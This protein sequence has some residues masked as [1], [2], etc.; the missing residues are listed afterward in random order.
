MAQNAHDSLEGLVISSDSMTVE[1]IAKLRYKPVDSIKNPEDVEWTLDEVSNKMNPGEIWLV[2]VF[3]HP[4][5]PGPQFAT[6]TRVQT[7][8]SVRGVNRPL[9]F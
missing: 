7:N 3:H 8:D 1:E 2:H 4:Y 6:I 9:R 5:W